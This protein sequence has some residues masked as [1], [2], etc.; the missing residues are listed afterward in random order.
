MGL[1]LGC[2]MLSF[3]E[4]VE[5]IFEIIFYLGTKILKNNRITTVELNPVL[6][7]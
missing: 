1:M 4:I 7:A 5:I 3:M 2:S 6:K